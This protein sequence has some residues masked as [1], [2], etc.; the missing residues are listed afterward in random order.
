MPA[1]RKSIFPELK[2]KIVEK[3]QAKGLLP[4]DILPSE[5]ALCREFG[6]SRPTLRKA[7]QELEETGLIIRRAGKGTFMADA[8]SQ[9]KKSETPDLLIFR[10]SGKT[11]I[12]ENLENTQHTQNMH[13]IKYTGKVSKSR[14][15]LVIGYTS[16]TRSRFQT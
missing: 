12:S 11:R 9:S 3:I 1:G 4:G 16:K 2:S 10:K 7:L 14:E 5:V 8:E 13:K 6:V 15:T